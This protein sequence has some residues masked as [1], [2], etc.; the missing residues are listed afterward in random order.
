MK[1][2]AMPRQVQRNGMM[3]LAGF[4]TNLEESPKRFPTGRHIPLNHGRGFPPVD[5]KDGFREVIH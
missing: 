4:L 2:Q 5:C 1:Q 3:F